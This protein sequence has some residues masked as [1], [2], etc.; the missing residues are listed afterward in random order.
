MII[1]EKKIKYFFLYKYIIFNYIFIF[2]I[3][4]KVFNLLNYIL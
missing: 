4:L 1:I 3:K 2:I